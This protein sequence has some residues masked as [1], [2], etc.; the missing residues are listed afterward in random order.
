MTTQ[1]QTLPLLGW[2]TETERFGLGNLAPK[3]VC[4]QLAAR[5]QDGNLGTMMARAQDPEMAQI[6]DYVLSDKYQTVAQS[7]AFDLAVLAANYPLL[8]PKI[9]NALA[10]GRVHC[11]RIR[12]KL[13]NLTTTGDL[14]Y[15]YLPDGGRQKISYRGGDLALFYLGVDR[16]DAK[17]A[18]DAW[19]TNFAV[20]ADT[21]IDQWPVEAREYALNDARDV[22]DIYEKQEFRRWEV[23]QQTGH[24]PFQV[25]AFTTFKDFCLQLS[26]CWGVAVDAE[27]YHRLEAKMKAEL[28]PEKLNLLIE[29]GIL[30]P[31][32]LPRP[33]VKGH[34]QHVDGC[35]KKWIE[36]VNGE[37]RT[38]ECQCPV[39]MTVAIEEKLNK[40][41]LQAYVQQLS[42]SNPNV[43]LKF[44]APS[45]S[46]PEGQIS[47]DAE[48]LEEFAI[49]DPLLLQLQHRANLQKMVTTELPRMLMKDA[50]G[51]PI[52]G[53]PAPFIHPRYD[54]LKET[55]RT[56]SYAEDKYPSFNCQ[57]VGE[58]ARHAYVARPGYILFST[59]IRQ[60]ELV[61]LAQKIYSLLGWSVLRD[62]INAGED[63]HAFLAA[64][65]CVA[66]DNDFR[67]WAM[68]QSVQ[69][70]EDVHRLFEM[71]K[72][73]EHQ[74][75][76]DKFNHYR[77][78]AK[79]TGLGYPGGLGPETFTAYAKATFDVEVSVET[80]AQLRDIWRNSFPEMQQYF[81][82]INEQCQDP[83]NQNRAV[84][85]RQTSEVKNVRLYS[86]TSPMGMYRAGCVY[87]AA[88]NGCGLQ[89]P[90]A[91][92]ATL[93]FANIVRACYDHT[94]GSILCDD[95]KGPAVRPSLFIHDEVA[96]EIR[97][98]GYNEE[99]GLIY[100][101]IAE[102][103]RIMVAA[104][105]TICPDV[106]VGVDTALM[107]RW[108]KKAKPRYD[109]QTK[110]LIVWEPDQK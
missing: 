36:T 108:T 54:V 1:A 44:T 63:V 68:S 82:F 9:F 2:D 30:Q 97:D 10:E 6:I 50:K 34:K 47:V 100:Q 26:S 41:K 23:L 52:P 58:E 66:T 87:C 102:I 48:W 70:P 49:H 56:S 74:E 81:A 29:A 19:R 72:E 73:S 95:A 105:K 31:A 93:G 67:N 80:A 39:K 101:R 32:E 78:L 75:H 15:R 69:S 14:E 96:G 64:Q 65:I 86:Y 35:K 79:P 62:K 51:E 71:L 45:D 90:G 83:H 11:T 25:E 109:V 55:G 13:L 42:G 60:M 104:M 8:V 91:E 76:R 43:K 7:A 106:N 59:D 99:G 94:L 18:S 12:E 107:R 3:L 110:R 27:E 24:D 17:N 33:N 22:V 92:G 46:F 103:E 20:L 89:T 21:P 40:T 61:T 38:M 84:K 77:L 57:N 16:T 88:A 5:G 4:A 98:E 85:D 53:C 28:T 37:K